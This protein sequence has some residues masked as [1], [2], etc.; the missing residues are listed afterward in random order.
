METVQLAGALV[1]LTDTVAFI[2]SH[3]THLG[4]CA[5]GRNPRPH[6]LLSLDICDRAGDTGWWRGASDCD[7]APAR[8]QRV[9][10]VGILEMQP[11]R[12]VTSSPSA[13]ITRLLP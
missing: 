4:S 6:L 1:G 5:D 11:V 13:A 7:L 10:I 2:L 8:L 3:R 9:G 12:F